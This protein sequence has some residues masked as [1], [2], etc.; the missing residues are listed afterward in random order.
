ML[1]AV[2]CQSSVLSCKTASSQ[3]ADA[4]TSRMR[5]RMRAQQSPSGSVSKGSAVRL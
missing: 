1:E 4:S 2:A 5:S 3:A